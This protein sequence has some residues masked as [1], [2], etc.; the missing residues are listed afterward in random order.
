MSGDGS[1]LPGGASDDGRG[2]RT[3]GSFG[4]IAAGGL[5]AAV[6]LGLAGGALW[7]L[8]GRSGS[9][10]PGGP[11]VPVVAPSDG[12]R[13]PSPSATGPTTPVPD[14]TPDSPSASPTLP[15]GFPPAPASSQ[16][17]SKKWAVGN[18]RI[19][20]TG[21][22]IG[23]DAMVTNGAGKPRAAQLTMYLYVSGTPL[24]R[25]TATVPEMGAKASG[26]VTFTS[27]DSWGPG[28][29]TLLLVATPD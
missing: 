13:T 7:G 19:T 28:T 12:A 8:S 23:M 25:L 27:T 10:T 3:G 6:V 24:A 15:G 17:V 11:G 14:S 18:W 4:L 26:P 20:N 5:V 22:R 9:V 1:L 16:Q 29:K 21:G 2:R